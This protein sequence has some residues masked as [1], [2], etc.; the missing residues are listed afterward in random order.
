MTKQS[1]RNTRP[2]LRSTAF[3]DRAVYLNAGP[4]SPRPPMPLAQIHRPHPLIGSDLGRRAF[5]KHAAADHDD[6]ARGETEYQLHIVL[7]E[8]HGDVARQAGDGGE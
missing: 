5:G 6:D 2:P 8:Q 3:F 7:D 4:S 1:S